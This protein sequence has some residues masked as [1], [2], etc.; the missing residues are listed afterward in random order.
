M[1]IV[2]DRP[3]LEWAV[4][5]ASRSGIEEMIFVTS[6]K[7]NSIIEHFN[8]SLELENL[9]KKKKKNNQISSI[10]SQSGLGDVYKRQII[11]F[12]FDEVTKIISSIPDL[13]ASI[14][15]HSK[16]GLSKTI[17]ISFANVLVAGRNRLPKPAIGKIAFFILLCIKTEG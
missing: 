11:E 10:Q 16:I 14:T 3:V 17:N 5:E 15:A 7:K 13:D 12:F 9:L 1:L 8:R 4:I 2:L 6:S